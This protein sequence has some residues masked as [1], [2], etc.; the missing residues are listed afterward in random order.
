MVKGDRQA[1]PVMVR[2]LKVWWSET[3]NVP[4]QKINKE[5]DWANRQTPFHH[6]LDDNDND[7]DLG[8]EVDQQLCESEEE[9]KY[10]GEDQSSIVAVVAV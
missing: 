7:N 2:R 5:E 1:N 9:E 10:E 8:E 3:H 4:K 6:L